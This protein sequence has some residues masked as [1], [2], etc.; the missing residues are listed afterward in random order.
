[1]GAGEGKSAG[2]GVETGGGARL[3]RRVV[4]DPVDPLSRRFR[5]PLASSDVVDNLRKRKI[6][7]T[8]L[9]ELKKN[10]VPKSSLRIIILNFVAFGFFPSKAYLGFAVVSPQNEST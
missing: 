9:R 4:C 7:S 8:K 5:S 6:K 2:G 10:Y 1:M 3:P